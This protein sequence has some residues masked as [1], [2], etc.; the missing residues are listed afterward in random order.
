[1]S[2]ALAA[3]AGVGETPVGRVPDMP[4]PR[5]MV[6]SILDA[7]RDAG[8][9]IEEIDGIFTASTRAEPFLTS[10]AAIAEAL[11]LRP[12]ICLTMPIGGMQPIALVYQAGLMIQTGR[13]SA[14]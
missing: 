14:I 11:N 1:M 8:I 4:A 12:D 13:A 7:A 2:K 9:G 10:S 5:M 6:T 3:I